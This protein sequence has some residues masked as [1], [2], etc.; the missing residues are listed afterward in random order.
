MD[1]RERNFKEAE[2]YCVFRSIIIC[3]GVQYRE[4]Q[5]VGTLRYKPEGR[6]FDFRW[7][8]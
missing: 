5:L 6:G 8:R 3:V 2:K 1:L 4:A 7:C